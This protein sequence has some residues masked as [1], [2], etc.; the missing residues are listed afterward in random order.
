MSEIVVH[1][2]RK[3]TREEVRASLGTFNGWP[4]A[5]LRVYVEDGNGGRPTEKGIAVRVEQLPEL[6]RAVKALIDG[7]AT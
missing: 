2:F 6:L 5:N 7:A 3:N 4:L 1:S